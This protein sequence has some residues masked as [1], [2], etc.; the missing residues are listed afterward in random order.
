MEKNLL[1]IGVALALVL[2]ITPATADYNF[3]GWPVQTRASG[4]VNGGVFIGYEPWNGSSNLALTTHVPTGTVQWARLY[5]G[6]WGGSETRSGWVNITF[7]GIADRNGLGPVQLEGQNDMNPNVWCTSRGKYWYWYNV[8]NLTIPGGI[9]TATHSVING[10]LDPGYGGRC[11]GIVLVVVYEGGAD[12]SDTDYWINDGHDLLY[13]LHSQGTTV[14][15]GTVANFSNVVRA[16]LTMLWL[17]AEVG[18]DSAKFNGHIVDTSMIVSNKFD[19][20]TW[21]VTTFVTPVGNGAWYSR[22]SDDGYVSIPLAILVIEKREPTEVFDLGASNHPYPSIAGLHNGTLK[23]ANDMAVNTMYTY[24]CPGTGGHTEFIR[25]W[26]ETTGDCAEAHGNGYQG[27]Y[28]N[29][30]FN[31]SI[32][33]GK[34]VTYHY[35]LQTGSYPQIHHQ[36]DLAM[37]GGSIR[38]STFTDVNGRK[39]DDW[40]PAFKLYYRAVV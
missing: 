12:P 17:T 25:I 19:I 4:T 24:P 29:I 3:D 15:P 11:Y 18:S 9:N 1:A 13:D 26:N 16:N 34:G 40:I 5:L 32:T 27:D 37:D 30:S 20:P 6:T 33:L 38:C 8:T 23:V 28:L 31:R 36:K 7:N 22:G 35:T 39:H 10:T 2:L 14:F 21:D